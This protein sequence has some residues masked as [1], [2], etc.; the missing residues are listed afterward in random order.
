MMW[1]IVQ[2][3]SEIKQLRMN[4]VICSIAVEGTTL[5]MVNKAMRIVPARVTMFK[6]FTLIELVFLCRG[7]SPSP[8]NSGRTKFLETSI[9]F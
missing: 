1:G 2:N 9:R 4:Q 3:W 8:R 7:P 6:V 5:N